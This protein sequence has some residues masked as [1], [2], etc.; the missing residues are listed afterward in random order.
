MTERIVIENLAT[1]P[2]GNVTVA[3]WVDKVRDQK[4]VQFVVLRDESGAAQLVHPRAEE[5]D[6]IADI[7]SGLATGTFIR[8]TGE[9]K[10]D[11]RVKLG[12]LEIKIAD[13]EVV[14]AANPET[15]I[16]AD[17]GIDKRLDWRFLDLREARNNLIFR[18]QTTLEHAMRTYW[19][20]RDFI[21]LHTPKLMASASESNAELFE[22]EYFEGKAYLAQSPQFFK[23]MAQSA[24]FG[25]IFEIGPVFRADPSFTS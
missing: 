3:G 21:E 14:T 23:Q 25:K 7:I 6:P 1:I 4:K 19:I 9:L 12:G 16:A 20:E 11:E 5:S 10:L 17:S 18:A 2:E 8:V 24:G 13:I 15:P 22:V